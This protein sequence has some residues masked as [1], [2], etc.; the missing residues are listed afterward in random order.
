[1]ESHDLVRE[2]VDFLLRVLIGNALPFLDADRYLNEPP[3]RWLLVCFALG[4]SHRAVESVSGNSSSSSLAI[5]CA[6]RV[7]CETTDAPRSEVA[8]LVAQASTTGDREAT[9]M[10]ENG[11]LAMGD[12]ER[13]LKR[14]VFAT[15]V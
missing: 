3:Y 11:E 14:F 9:R 10:K 4:A 15:S 6:I 12:L 7:F 5:D 2:E 8:E 1:M 13:A